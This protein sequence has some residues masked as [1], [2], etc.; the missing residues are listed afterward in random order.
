M[1][2]TKLIRV[3]GVL[4]LIIFVAMGA[5]GGCEKNKNSNG[6]NDGDDN[7]TTFNGSTLGVC[8]LSGADSICQ[9][10]ANDGNQ[11]C[12]KIS[13]PPPGCGTIESVE[14]FTPCSN[15]L[16]EAC[17]IV[18]PTP[19]PTPTPPP[20][21]SK[22]T[23]TFVNNCGE[24]IWVGGQSI[25]FTPLLCEANTSVT[26][27]G[28]GDCGPEGGQ[29]G[30]TIMNNTAWVGPP[31][32]GVNGG[33]TWEIPPSHASDTTGLKGTRQLTIPNCWDSGSFY[34]RTVCTEGANSGEL[35]CQTAIW[36]RL[37]RVNSNVIYYLNYLP[38]IYLY[39]V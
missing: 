38:L 5:I 16:Q 23:I 18:I 14:N 2:R 28:V 21:G 4:I 31:P 32:W 35:T 9:T 6:G 10:C 29:S 3:F 26:V 1:N 13:Q 20:P 7:G 11:A 15:N 30:G 37:F 17:R 8:D 34:A 24:S 22:R 27:P 36:H 39:T 19:T 33:A 25:S 12:C